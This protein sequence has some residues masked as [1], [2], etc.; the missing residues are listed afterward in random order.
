MKLL[1]GRGVIAG[2][3]KGLALISRTPINFTAALTKL[4]NLIPG[5]RAEVQDRHHELYRKNIKGTVLVFPACI[6]S[7]YTGMVLLEIMYRR[8]APAAMIVSEADSLLVSGS[9]I[10]EVWFDCGIPIVE[11]PSD[12]LFEKIQTGDTIEV[13]G[14]TG[15]IRISPADS[16]R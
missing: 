4:Q 15:E 12:D 3:G 1:Q 7:T 9:A 11:Y 8:V 13:D 16:A 6:G 14:T 2:K 5:R 10:A